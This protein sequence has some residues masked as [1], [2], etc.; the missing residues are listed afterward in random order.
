ME[1]ILFSK[2]LNDHDAEGLVERGHQIGIDGY[3]LCVRPDHPVNPENVGE[4]L[5]EVVHKLNSGGLSVP[6][7]TGNFDLLYPDDSTA[8][9]I[10]SAMDEADVRLVKLGYFKFDPHGEDYWEKVSEIRAALEGWQKL[11]EKY[12]VKICYHTHSGLNMG[13]NCAA[14]MHL[15]RGFDPRYIGA[16]VDT[17][18]M[19]ADGE[20]FPF[21]LAMVCRYLA[22]V[23]LK[24]YFVNLKGGNGDERVKREPR[25]AGEGMVDWPEVFGELERVGFDGPL[26]VHA[27]YEKPSREDYLASLKDEV[28]YFRAQLA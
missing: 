6:M 8:E 12:G 14:L 7:V 1:L 18:H 19:V 28:A 9:P 27:E 20:P 21:G 16:Y 2:F 23:A 22:I 5:P 25:M 11:G 15:L 10:L 13:L 4:A 24:D 17:G 26:S 3:D